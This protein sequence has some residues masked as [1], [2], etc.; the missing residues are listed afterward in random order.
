MAGI[1]EMNV[2]RYDDA[3]CHFCHK[4]GHIAP[5]CLSCKH[6][7]KV[8]GI[9][10]HLAGLELHADKASSASGDTSEMHDMYHIFHVF[11]KNGTE[12]LLALISINN[13]R[14]EME[15]DTGAAVSLIIRAAFNN[16]WHEPHQTKLHRT[17]HLLSTSDVPSA[18]H[19]HR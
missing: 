9:K 14:L 3:T 19:L 5:A 11:S 2:G 6:K 18:L 8:S 10:T 4:S 16:L 12:H 13:Q 7:E 15:V 17:S 1:H